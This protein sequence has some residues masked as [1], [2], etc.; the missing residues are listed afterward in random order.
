MT[1]N[2]LTIG[3][4]AVALVAVVGWAVW[5]GDDRKTTADG[6]TDPAVQAFS[7]AAMAGETLFAQKCAACHGRYAAGSAQGP[8]LVH[9]IYEPNHHADISFLLAVRRGVRAHHWRFGNMAPVPGV[10]DADVMKITS[11]VRALQRAKGIF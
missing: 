7:A 6:K 5:P 3:A 11:Y 4:A 8:P 1:P 10:S 2:R 9:K